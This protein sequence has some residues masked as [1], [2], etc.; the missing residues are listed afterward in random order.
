MSSFQIEPIKLQEKTN[1]V[2]LAAY[3]SKC[4]DAT[5]FRRIRL[6]F[7]DVSRGPLGKFMLVD[8]S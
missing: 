5:F 7:G 8:F 1:L 6:F 4:P 2:F 3:P